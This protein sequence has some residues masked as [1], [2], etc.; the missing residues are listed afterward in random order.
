MFTFDVASP[1][2]NQDRRTRERRTCVGR[3]VV[4]SS[5]PYIS[6]CFKWRKILVYLAT[7]AGRRRD[8]R[9]KLRV[10]QVAFVSSQASLEALKHR[11]KKKKK[12]VVVVVVEEKRRSRRREL[13]RGARG[14]KAAGGKR[15]HLLRICVCVLFVFVCVSE[16]VFVS[17]RSNDRE[18]CAQCN[19]Q[20]KQRNATLP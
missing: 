9:R 3:G 14:E 19:K 15:A 6:R 4:T 10:W 2:G 8:G 13:V 7:P 18:Q 12:K 20:H 1:G 11:R 17:W 5:N 16:C